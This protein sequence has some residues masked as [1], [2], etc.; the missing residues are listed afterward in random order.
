MIQ[1]LLTMVMVLQGEDEQN[2]I[3]ANFGVRFAG[4]DAAIY[5]TT[6]FKR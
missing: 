4:I 1:G 3:D 5:Y 6:G 2:Q